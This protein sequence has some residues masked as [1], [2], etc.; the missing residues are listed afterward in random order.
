MKLANQI[1]LSFATLETQSGNC[2]WICSFQLHCMFGVCVHFHQEQMASKS[3]GSLGQMGCQAQVSSFGNLSICSPMPLRSM[4]RLCRTCDAWACRKEHI[5]KGI[6]K[7]LSCPNLSAFQFAWE[8]R[9]T[10]IF[11]FGL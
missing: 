5:A 4:I 9:P 10:P 6:Q 11:P 2:C 1:H 7:P 3:Q 8:L